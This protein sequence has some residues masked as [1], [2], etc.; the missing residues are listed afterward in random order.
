M[1]LFRF[2]HLLFQCASC[3]DKFEK[4]QASRCTLKSWAPCSTENT[5]WEYNIKCYILWTNFYVCVLTT[6]ILGLFQRCTSE[7]IL[8][9]TLK[10]TSRSHLFMSKQWA[11]E[12][13]TA[14]AL[15]NY[16][17]HYSDISFLYN[18]ESKCGSRRNKVR[19][20]PAGVVGS[21]QVSVRQ[22]VLPVQ[23]GADQLPPKS[24]QRQQQWL[25]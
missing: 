12:R 18:K 25:S 3:S 21:V 10:W 9:R 23:D 16:L 8:R 15:Q 19:R 4:K 11:A 17:F 13:E 20:S 6:P 24:K 14:L 5:G 1:V 22:C 7:P 2:M